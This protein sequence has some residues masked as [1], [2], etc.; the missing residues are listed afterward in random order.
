MGLD[1]EKGGIVVVRPDGYV[2]VVVRLEEGKGTC[3]AL[4]QYFG[5]I[6]GKKLGGEK[7]SL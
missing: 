3:D 7:A 5:V 4:N 2:G 1:E 6:T